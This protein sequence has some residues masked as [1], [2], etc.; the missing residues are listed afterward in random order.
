MKHVLR[1]LPWL[2]IVGLLSNL[3]FERSKETRAAKAQEL[4]PTPGAKYS[5]DFHIP[6]PQT[7][8]PSEPADYL[9]DPDLPI[10]E[11]LVIE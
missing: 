11:K 6:R 3:I 9:L 8:E 1:I 2:L 7:R 10:P 5:P 4:I